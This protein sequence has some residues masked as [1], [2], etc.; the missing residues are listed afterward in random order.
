[1]L[2]FERAV[3]LRCASCGY[4][5]PGWDTGERR[6]RLRFAGDASRH[7]ITKR[8]PDARDR[9]REDGEAGGR[10]RRGRTRR[11]PASPTL[12]PR[13]SVR[14]RSSSTSRHVSTSSSRT[15]SSRPCSP[16][17]PDRR[18]PWRACP[19]RIAAS[20]QKLETSRLRRA[21]RSAHARR[22]DAASGS[23]DRS[24]TAGA[25]GADEVGRETPGRRRR[26]LRGSR[27]FRLQRPS[28]A[29]P[30]SVRRSNC[31]GQRAG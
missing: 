17:P 13:T 7:Q 23:M 4:Q 1:M 16:A 30:G 25:P 14:A 11:S 24:H 12:T 10:A 5:S 28:A 27:A 19:P 2:Q 9:S 20:V 6:P 22:T 26:A 8:P 21:S 18:A 31:S 3:D 15:Y 29:S